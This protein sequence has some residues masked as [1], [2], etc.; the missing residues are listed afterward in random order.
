MLF[1]LLERIDRNRFEPYVISLTNKGQIGPRIEAL[2]IPVID[3][4]LG[5]GPGSVFSLIKFF[6]FLRS[7]RPIIVHAWMQHANLIGGLVARSAGVPYVVWGIRQSNL[8]PEHNKRSTLMV[9]KLCALLSSWLPDVI[10]SCSIKAK[11][12]HVAAGFHESKIKL[13]PNG[14]D[15]DKYQP[16]PN[17]RDDVR[18][19]LGLPLDTP[20]VGLIARDHVMKNHPGFIDAA[21]MIAAV[22][23]KAHFLMAG[24]NITWNNLRLSQLID[25]KRLRGQFH[26]LGR[27][28]DIPRLMASLDVLASSS[29]GEAF[30]N[31]LGE[32][33]AC[34][35]P[36]VVTDI[37]DSADIVGDTGRVVAPNDMDG[38]AN[39]IIEILRLTWEER[40]ALGQ[41]ARDRVRKHYEISHIAK[42][43][44]D[45][46]LHLYQAT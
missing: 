9:T 8:L 10:L 24:T 5:R 32:A 39:E 22:L 16:N 20:L 3:L 15:L 43:H 37:G 42:V 21:A 44:E 13:I 23:P 27:R 2:G 30:P 40:I 41:R 6:N 25:E 36:C 18:H 7:T 26:L 31:V 35:V 38:L 12:T 14:F 45:F 4:G 34:G 1:K 28:T 46:Y 29:N 19:E 11:Q 33:M 17:A